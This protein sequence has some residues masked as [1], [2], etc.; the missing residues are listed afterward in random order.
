[1]LQSAC[2]TSGEKEN[3]TKPTGV[4]AARKNTGDAVAGKR[5]GGREIKSGET[6]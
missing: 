2:D 3:N 1:M 6:V 4:K 5:V